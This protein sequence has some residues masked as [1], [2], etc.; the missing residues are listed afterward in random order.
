[1]GKAD[2]RRLSI[3]QATI[4]AVADEGIEGAN[5]ERIAR[6]LKLRRS[7]IVY[8]FESREALV[9][10]TVRY[11]VALAQEITSQYLVKKNTAREKIHGVNEATFKWADEYWD[12]VRV[13]VMFYSHCAS[14]ASFRKLNTELRDIG[15]ARIVELLK[16]D[17]CKDSATILQQ[18]ARSIQGT[19]TGHIIEY[20]ASNSDLDFK[21]MSSKTIDAILAT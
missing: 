13:L 1:M 6:R 9:I 18:K 15:T 17:G 8:Y 5:F 4:K 11:V 10:A 12:H 21:A 16:L 20:I 7:H 14:E 3:I 19:I 2:K